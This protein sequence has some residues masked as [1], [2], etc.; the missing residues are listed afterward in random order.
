[1]HISMDPRK[2]ICGKVAVDASDD[3]KLFFCHD[4]T[5]ILC[6][7]PSMAELGSDGKCRDRR[8]KR[9]GRGK[10]GKGISPRFGG[11]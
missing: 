7:A 5:C 1:L 3:G 6:T 11:L 10:S 8:K 4:P 2:V 9:G